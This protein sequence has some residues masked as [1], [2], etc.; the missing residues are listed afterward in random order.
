MSL[1]GMLNDRDIK[2]LKKSGK[3]THQSII[4]DKEADISAMMHFIPSHDRTGMIPYPHPCQF[5]VCDLAVFIRS[6]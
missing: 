3:K 6:L 2:I 4:E 5:D 1:Y